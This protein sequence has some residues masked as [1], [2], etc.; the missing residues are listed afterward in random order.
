MLRLIKTNLIRYIKSPFLVFALLC[1]FVLGV[2]HGV[3]EWKGVHFDFDYYYI[4][5]VWLVSPMSDILFKCNI[6]VMI[7]LI[8]L[9]IGREFSD[10]TIHNKLYIGHTRTAIYLSHVITGSMVAFFGYLLFMIPTGIGG[11]DF[12]FT[13]SPP[14]CFF[15]LGELLLS[16]LVWG[17]LSAVLTM[18][19]ANRAAGV[20]TVFSIMLFLAVI[21]VNLRGYYYNTDPPEI[22]ETFIDF[23]EDGKPYS[24]ERKMNNRWYLDGLPKVLVNMEHEVDPFSM[25]YNACNYAYIHFPEKA[26]NA[27]F[28]FQ[29]QINRQMQYDSLVLILTGTILTI[30]GSIL[31]RKKDLK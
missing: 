1:S 31:F 4:K 23:S 9:E 24:V 15:L 29:T 5:S 27:D 6:W 8:S 25:L 10:G 3:L 30:G 18:L 21:N 17:I 19:I 22:T 7:V 11:N 16:I 14:A 28:E 13:L 2:I 12:F 26:K 20:V